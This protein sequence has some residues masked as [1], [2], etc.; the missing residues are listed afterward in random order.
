ML[1]TL[2]VQYHENYENAAYTAAIP[3]AIRMYTAEELRRRRILAGTVT[4]QKK[5]V[6]DVL[7]RIGDI[8]CA[9]GALVVLSPL[10][11]GTCAAIIVNDFGSPIYS[12]MRI[13]KDGKP[14]RIYK[15]RSMYKDADARRE[16][17]MEQNECKGANFKIKDDPRITPVGHILRKTSIDELPQLWNVLKGDM[18]FI[19]YRPERQYYID[20]IMECNPRYR[21]LYQIRPGVTS[22]ATLYNGYTDT[23][24]K[25]LTRLDLDLYYLRNHSLWFDARVLG[26]T[27]LGIVT[28]KKF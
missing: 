28:G 12:Q 23:L 9:V 16:A 15:F 22:Y 17:L 21:Y 3:P 7:K 11:L 8:V 2:S 18:S 25:M 26:M 24:D 13:G 20:R 14:F 1:H 19:G 6:Y 5:P 27:F 4:L 10:L